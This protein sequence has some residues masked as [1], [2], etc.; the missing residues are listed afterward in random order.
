M[1][2]EF[3]V[4]EGISQ[5]SQK[6]ASKHLAQHL[7]RQ[8]EL[9]AARYPAR[10]VR[11]DSPSWDHAVDMGMVQQ[12]L[13]PGVQH[14]QETD[15]RPEAPWI[16]RDLQQGLGNGTKQKPIHQLLVL[17]HERLE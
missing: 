3:A 11:R 13:T 1:K 12:V 15:L 5:Q 9:G 8:E 16:G 4:G 10:T 7:H 6:F 14:S 2:L 17:E